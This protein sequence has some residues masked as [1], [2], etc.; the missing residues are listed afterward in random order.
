MKRNLLYLCLFLFILLNKSFAEVVCSEDELITEILED[1]E[2][3]GRLNCLRTTTPPINETKDERDRRIKSHWTSDCS[4]ESNNTWPR[5][6]IQN[7]S[8]YKGLIDVNGDSYQINKPNEADMCEI[9][10]TLLGNGYFPGINSVLSIS[11]KIV[12]LIS[13]PGEEGSTKVC[14]ANPY[15]FNRNEAWYIFL[16]GKGI[17]INSIPSYKLS[18][19]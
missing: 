19:N 12:K 4:F 16:D 15:H 5:R 3:N 8:I 13:C 11:P 1:I 7:Y 18:A 17:S 14:A 6:L 2:Y 9:I 10:R